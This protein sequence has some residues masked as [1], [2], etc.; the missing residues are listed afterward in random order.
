[1]GEAARQSEAK[2]EEQ[3]AAQAAEA[4]RVSDFRIHKQQLKEAQ[5]QAGELA[6]LRAAC[7]QLD[8]A[9]VRFWIMW[10]LRL[11]TLAMIFS[12]DQGL[13]EPVEEFH[14]PPKAVKQ[15]KRSRGEIV[16]EDE[17]DRAEFPP[18]PPTAA[19]VWRRLVCSE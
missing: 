12:L 16:D 19:E 14:W 17:L 7:M 13:D 4:A 18:P 2:K 5:R 6:Q 8:Q 11:L 3:A 10:W 15:L 1:M 9:A